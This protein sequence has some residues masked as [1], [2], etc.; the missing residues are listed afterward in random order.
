MLKEVRELW[1]FRE[2]LFSMVERELKIRYKNSVL[3]FFWSLLN[4]LVT[5]LVMTLVFK[6]FLGNSTPNLGAYTLAA[7][8]PF[9]FF[10]M[11]LL[12]A[13][14]SVIVSLP[15]I[16]KIYFP[17]E[18]LPLAVVISNFIHF[19][20]AIIVFFGYMIVVWLSDPRV[21][22]FGPSLAALP[23]LLLINFALC[24]GLGLLISALN[25]FYEDVKYI[26]SVL[27]YLL[28][29]ASPVMYWSE[30][31]SQGFKDWPLGYVLYHLNPIAMLCTAYRKVL[32]APQPLKIGQETIAPLPL[33]WGLVGA[34]ALISFGILWIGYGVFNRLKW[35]FVERP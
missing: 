25:T 28:F 22:P 2:L 17:R 8:L 26:V 12:D 11:C 20:L 5:V 6:T 24:T 13:A 35:R 16:R 9:M 27:L 4:P 33:D 7:Y 23:V 10:Q 1:R 15:L 21:F 14:Q 29:F 34:T 3:G 32:L 31:V 30:N 19:V 18:I